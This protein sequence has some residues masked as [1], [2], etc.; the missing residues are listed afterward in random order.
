MTNHLRHINQKTIQIFK[1]PEQYVNDLMEMGN[2]PVNSTDNDV[3][4]VDLSLFDKIYD[5]L[6]KRMK[7]RK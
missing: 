4:V 6:N 5:K 7:V 1:I 3:E 2:L